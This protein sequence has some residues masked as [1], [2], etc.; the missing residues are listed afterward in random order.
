MIGIVVITV[1]IIII[2]IIIGVMRGVKS[3]L[4]VRCHLLLL[5]FLCVVDPVSL[6]VPSNLQ[7]V[8]GCRAVFCRTLL[9]ESA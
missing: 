2:I 5:Q 8:V 7:L 9:F 3:V 6:E 4:L 1:M